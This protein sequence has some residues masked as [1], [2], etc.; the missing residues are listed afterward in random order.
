MPKLHAL[1][2]YERVKNPELEQPDIIDLALDEAL[3]RRQ[4]PHPAKTTEEPP[5]QSGV[6]QCVSKT[7][8]C[9][10]VA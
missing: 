1:L 3:D 2:A 8:G 7:V 6:Q 9:S 4:I 5:K 10:H